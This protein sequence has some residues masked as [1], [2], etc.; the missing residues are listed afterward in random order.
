MLEILFSTGI[1]EIF[2]TNYYLVLFALLAIISV[3]ATRFA[4]RFGVPALVLFL[5][6]GMIAGSDGLKLILWHDC[7]HHYSV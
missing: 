6:F 4:T 5:G 7:A 1:P 3:I 2:H